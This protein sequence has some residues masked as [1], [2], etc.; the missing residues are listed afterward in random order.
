MGATGS[1]GAVDGILVPGVGVTV[2]SVSGFTVSGWLGIVGIVGIVV[3]GFGCGLVVSGLVGTV[4]ATA[5]AIWLCWAITG[6]AYSANAVPAVATV[7]PTAIARNVLEFFRIM[8]LLLV[9]SRQPPS[10]VLA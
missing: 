4:S 8:N 10:V 6:V 7:R 1:A 3:S 2:V 9:S 5:A